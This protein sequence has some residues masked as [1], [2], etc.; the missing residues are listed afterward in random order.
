M[1]KISKYLGIEEKLT[2]KICC[3][4][5]KHL[6]LQKTIIHLIMTQVALNG[7]LN[8]IL[9][10]NL[11]ERNSK[12]L[13]SK[14]VEASESKKSAKKLDPEIAKIPE[15]FRCDPFE[16]SPSGDPFYA[17]KRNVEAVR[18]AC[19]AAHSKDAVFVKIDD[20]HSFIES[21]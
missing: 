11:S 15:E 19:E 5:K 14:I 2:L 7:L 8:Y 9:T 21:L 13:A 4:T 18:K 6:F 16:V 17:D 10:L 3:K 12:W 20:I 1:R